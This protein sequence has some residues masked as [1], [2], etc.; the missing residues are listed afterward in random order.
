MG[1]PYSQQFLLDL[2]RDPKEGLG[3]DLAKLCVECNLPAMYVAKV[4]GV[5]RMTIYTW[6][7]GGVIRSDLR[8][9]VEALIKILRE[10]VDAGVLPA[11]S[12]FEGKLYL[13]KLIERTN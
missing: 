12:G 1:R 10:D 7:R 4:A 2:Y 6:F 8:P 3:S 5:S 11:K 9:T 13:E